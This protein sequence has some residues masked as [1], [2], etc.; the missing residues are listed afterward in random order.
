[1]MD[2][3]SEPIQWKP[4]LLLR[5]MAHVFCGWEVVCILRLLASFESSYPSKEE[6]SSS[7]MAIINLDIE[8]LLDSPRMRRSTIAKD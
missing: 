1:M 3:G 5:A 6:D 7:L 4:E 8:S 2:P